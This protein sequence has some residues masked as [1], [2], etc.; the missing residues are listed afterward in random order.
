VLAIPSSP[1]L[2]I[3]KDERGRLTGRRRLWFHSELT[4]RA[5]TGR[6]QMQQRSYSIT[7]SAIASS[8]SGTS[9]AIAFAALRLITSSNLVGCRSERM[10]IQ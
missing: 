9:R 7:L 8:L 10:P 1:A 4:R 6:E 5:K 3:V 2:R